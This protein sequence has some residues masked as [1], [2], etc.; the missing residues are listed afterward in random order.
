MNNIK[1]VCDSLSDIPKQLV[2]EYDIHVVPLSVLFEDK[3]YVDGIDIT[4]EEF[5]QMLRDS[6][7]LPKT[8]QVTYM[9]F[10]TTFDKYLEEGKTVLYIGGSSN[11]SGTYQSAVMAKNDTEGELYTFDS[12][13]LS[14]G[15][16][17][18]VLSAAEMAR[19]GKSIDEILKHLEAIKKDTEVIFTVDTL[20]YL[21]KGGRVSLASAT[22]G[23]ML[24]I[25]PIL[26]IDNGSV[27]SRAQVRGKKQVIGKIIEMIKDKFGDNLENKRVIVGCG[28]NQGDLD[29]LTSKISDELKL[30]KVESVHIGSCICAHSGPGVLGIAV[31]DK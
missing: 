28:D 17:C 30:G 27:G 3:E 5:Y 16:G 7:K 22:I 13:S 11:A 6:K 4:K 2:E 9:S 21:Q 15:S 20:E 18:I 29:I 24:S 25:K 26:G 8:S 23:N 14:I 10:K 1:I 19:E 12:L 31:C